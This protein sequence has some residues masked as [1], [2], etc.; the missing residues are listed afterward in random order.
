MSMTRIPP[1]G[2]GTSSQPDLL[3]PE[4][5]TNGI[6][7]TSGPT[8]SEATCNVTSSLASQA[9][10]TRSGSRGGRMI[11]QS[12]PDRVPA[13]RSASRARDAVKP[14]SDT[15]GPPSET[16][17]LSGALQSSLESRLQARQAALGSPLYALKW[18]RW[19]ME[20]GP[21]I[22]ALRASAPRTSAND[23]GLLGWPTPNAGPQNDTD[24][25]W[26]TRRA[27]LKAEKR[28]GNGFGLTLGMAASLVGWPSPTA[29]NAAGSQVARGATATGRRAD[30]SK[31]TVSLPHVATLAGWPTPT[32]NSGTGAG[33]Q[34][35]KGGPN[36]QTVAGWATPAARDFRSEQATDTFNQKRWGH[37]RG[38][39]L[40]AQA[41]CL[42][43]IGPARL[44][45]SGEMLTGSSARMA[46]GGRLNP[47]HSRWLMGYPV[48][49]GRYAPTETPSSRRL[50]K[51]SSRR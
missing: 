3:R 2:C 10:P 45:A 30:G 9:G 42:T 43:T 13:N 20:S 40:S 51:S 49:W 50:R 44:T 34:G 48:E 36:L 28:N 8:T 7:E 18:K 21:P 27:A 29:G 6:S 38:K 5:W 25:K 47:E 31:A 19:D 16:L 39:P 33:G 23:S 41:E 35:R 26:R 12:G 1:S 22:C 14:T 32:S 17:S 46:S 15:F 24:A 4:T 11:D 37:S